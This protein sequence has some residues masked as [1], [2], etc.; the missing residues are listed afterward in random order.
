MKRRFPFVLAACLAVTASLCGTAHAGYVEEL[1]SLSGLVSYWGLNET[2]G[3]MATDGV[4]GDTIDGDN[5][6]YYT[7][8]GYTLGDAGP[9][10]ADGWTGFAADNYA[11]TFTAA[12]DQ[13]LEMFNSTGYTGLTDA[14][15]LGWFRITDP[16]VASRTN[17]IGG[18]QDVGGNRYVFAGCHYATGLTGFTRRRDGDT[19]SQISTGAVPVSSP[20]DWH[21][22]AVTY[23]GGNTTR[24]YID[25]VLASEGTNDLVLPIDSAATM[26]FATDIDDPARVLNGQLDE[27]ATFNRALSE[28]EIGNLFVAAGGELPE[29][30]PNPGE[31]AT[32]AYI[33]TMQKYGAVNHWRLNETSGTTAVDM[34]AGNDITY[35]NI[36]GDPVTLGTPGMTPADGFAGLEE[37][38]ASAQFVWNSGVNQGETTETAMDFAAGVTEMTMSVWFK[39]NFSGQGYVAGFA[40]AASD[41]R[42]VFSIYSPDAYNLAVYTKT[43]MGDGTSRQINLTGIQL[44]TT[45]DW[46]WHHLVQV[47]NGDEK[48]VDFYI[49]GQLAG[50]KT[51]PAAGSTIVVPD[52][53][54]LGRDVPGN[55]R[56]LGGFIDEVSLFDKALTAEEVFELYDSAYFAGGSST[57]QGDLNN[58]GMVGSADLDIVRGNWGQSVDAG[59]L[60]CGDPSGDGVVGSADLDIVRANWGNTAAAAVPEPGTI[61]LLAG[62]THRTDAATEVVRSYHNSVARRESLRRWAWQTLVT[63]TSATPFVPLGNVPP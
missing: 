25:G 53:F 10:P 45:T 28:E 16:D 26:A 18:M 12:P 19:I 55:T 22:M 39:N 8:S 62:R 33:P 52:G 58:D 37:G 38:N 4:T 32:A 9:R 3:Y 35:T 1:T 27:L 56:N 29:P 6:G 24:V 59:C 40:E 51:D 63:T 11:P 2:T 13:K 60:S 17:M 61:A 50:T 54:Y 36:S 49:D 42:Y 23:S 7:G 46:E 34:I 47:W 20:S 57:L 31:T 41:G 43:D 21:F 44:D 5:T 30:P 15:L 48:R 14:T